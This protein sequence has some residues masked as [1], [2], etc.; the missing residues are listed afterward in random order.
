MEEENKPIE[1][2]KVGMI[3]R[4]IEAAE[5]LEIANRKQEEL[6]MRQEELMAKQALGGFSEAGKPQIPEV[7][8]EDKLKADMKN[9]FK[10]TAIEQAFR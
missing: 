6:L 10:G 9:Y 3:D 5:R 4:A 1:I 8:P 7:N 2:G